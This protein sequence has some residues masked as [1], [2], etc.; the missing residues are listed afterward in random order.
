MTKISKY[1]V[2][3]LLAATPLLVMGQTNGSNSPYSRYGFGLLG[4]GGNAF[5]KGMSGTAY[6]MRNGKE[7]NTKNPASYAAIDSLS[8]LFDLGMSLQNGNFSQNGTKTNAHNTSIDY[9]TAGYRLAQRLGMTLGLVPFST[10]G[11]STNREQVSKSDDGL[12]Q[13]TQ[14]SIFSGDGGLHEAYVGVGWAPIK[15]LSVGFNLG[16]LWGDIE[17]SSTMEVSGT[18]TSSSNVP[19]TKTIYSA[20]IRTY[21]LDLGLQYEQCIDKKNKLTLGFVY[22][23]GHDINRDAHYYSQRIQS[24]SILSG[25]TLICHN[26]FQLPHTFGLGV[27]WTTHNSLRIGVDYTFQKWGNIK[28]PFIKTKSDKSLE[29]I[30][31]KGAFTDMH[32]VS[33]GAE[34]IPNPEGLRWRQRVRYRAGMSYATSYTKIEDSN[35]P[36]DFQASLGVALPIANAYNNRTYLNFSAQY[37]HVKPKVAGMITENYI[38]FCIGISFSE[39]WFMKWK[40]E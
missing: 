25:D 31:K 20:D 4:D 32:K 37:E 35:G 24:S 36:K 19:T 34:Y 3:A 22:G 23:V 9:V 28:Y 26:A 39:R 13:V 11:Y 10:I 16:Y 21:K 18:T 8:L 14:K 40:A 30:S 5:N 6:G 27:T 7:L 12:S 1:L 15:S 33:I 17:H 29:Y 2:A 38:R